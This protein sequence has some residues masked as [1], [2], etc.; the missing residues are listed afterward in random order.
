MKTLTAILFSFTILLFSTFYSSCKKEESTEP[1]NKKVYSEPAPEGYSVIETDKQRLWLDTVATD[2]DKPWGMVFLPNGDILFSERSGSLKRIN[3]SD[4]SVQEISGLPQIASTGQGGL[5]DLLLHSD[6]ENNGY[7]Y[8]SYSKKVGFNYTTA[9]SRAKLSGNSLVEL[10]ELFSASPAFSTSHHFGCR[11][12]MKDNYLYFGVGERGQMKLAQ[13][14]DKHN[15]KIMRI[16]DN[17]DIPVDNPFVSTTD[18]KA[19]IWSYGHRNP[20]G[21]AIH[22][23]TGEIWEHEHGPKGGDELNIIKEAANFG[24]PEITYGI[25]YDGTIISPNTHLPGMEQPVT[26]WD[27]SIAPCGMIF[28]DSDKYPEWKNNIFLGGLAARALF[29]VELNGDKYVDQEEI[30]SDIGRVRNVA[31]SPDGFIYMAI[32]DPGY[33]FRLVPINN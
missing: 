1:I 21:L 18:A 4:G 2:V 28:C 27:P 33:I 15:G 16:H 29:R 3:H 23:V 20:Q 26:Y 7:L 25:D 13:K 31:L 17:G 6:F 8:F 14:L 12:V 24:W 5:L 32:E 30:L 9:I 11:M 19:E 22:P 10:E